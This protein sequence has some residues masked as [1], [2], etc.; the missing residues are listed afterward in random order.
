MMKW[1]WT[2]AQASLEETKSLLAMLNSILSQYAL[3]FGGLLRDIFRVNNAIFNAVIFALFRCTLARSIC[4]NQ[5][6]TF[7]D[8]TG[9]FLPINLQ[10]INCWKVSSGRI[11]TQIVNLGGVLI[12]LSHSKPFC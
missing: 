6:V 11:R 5:P 7:Q 2:L 12:W 1:Q 9:R 10:W 4:F 8:T 3:E